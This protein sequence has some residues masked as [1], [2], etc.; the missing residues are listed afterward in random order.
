[1][2]FGFIAAPHNVHPAIDDA[3]DEEAQD[4]KDAIEQ[5]ESRAGVVRFIEEPEMGVRLDL[6]SLR[7]TAP[8]KR[9]SGCSGR[10]CSCVRS[11]L[12]PDTAMRQRTYVSQR[13]HLTV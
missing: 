9:T 13:R 5:L 1:M 4:Q 12:I 8:E 10:R 7:L 2:G 3:D 6:D 11:I